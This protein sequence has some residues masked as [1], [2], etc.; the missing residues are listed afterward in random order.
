MRQL[1]DRLLNGSDN[2]T[3]INVVRWMWRLSLAA[4]LGVLLVFIILSFTNLPSV[5]E[6]E[7]PKT[8]EASLVLNSLGE[9]LGKY[10]APSQ[11]RVP[12]KFEELSPYL[13]NG[14]IATEDERYY[15]HCGID[16]KGLARAV[17]YLGSRGGASTIT[18]Q[19]AKQLF[20]KKVARN[21]PERI[22]Q[23]LK[24]WIIAV[25]LE[26]RYTKEE[27]IA[28]YLNRYDFINGAQG[29]RAAS[30][31]YFSKSAKDLEI[32]EAALLVGMLKNASLYDPKRFTERALKRREVVLKQMQKNGHLDQI[33]YDSLRQK[34]LGL[35][36]SRQTHIDGLAPYFRMVL[37]QE[38]KSILKRPE[39]PKKDN[40]KHFDIY[41]DGL[42]IYTTIDPV[43]QEVAEEQMLVNMKRLQKQFWRVWKK[44]DPWSYKQNTETEIPIEIRQRELEKLIRNSDRYQD[45]RNKYLS[46]AL[47]EITAAS[48]LTFS[49]DL[50]EVDYLF[51]AKQDA[52][53]ISRLVQRGLISSNLAARYRKAL[54]SRAMDNL[55]SQWDKLQAAKEEVFNKPVEM[56]IFTYDN[57]KLEKDSTMSPLDSIKYHRMFL[58]TGI[59]AVDPN[60]G[61]VRAWVGGI[62]HKW[63]QYDHVNRNTKRQVGSTFKPF[64]YAATIDLRGFSPC[65]PVLDIATTIEPGDGNF[66]LQK[67]WTPRNS[68]GTY[69]G[70]I[71]TLRDGLRNS[72]NTVSTYLMKELGSTDPVRTLVDNMGVDKDRVPDAPSIALGSV[73]LSVQE[74]TGA[75][76]TFANNGVFN[77]PTYL[78]RIE[79]RYGRVIYQSMPEERPALSP[80]ANYVMT[81]MLQYAASGRRGIHEVKGQA[82]GKTGTTNDYADGWFMGVTPNLVVGTWVGGE[83]RWISFLRI[84]E[85]QGANMGMPFFVEYIKA[86]QA[87][88]NV[89]WDFDKR[90]QRPRGDLGIILNC[91]EYKNPFN[92]GDGEG[93]EGSGDDFGNDPDFGR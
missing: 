91:D 31:I 93:D 72:K 2:P 5:R 41:R 67:P 78:L 52:A 13:V 16:F 7:N 44:K 30:E 66:Y 86:L 69:S 37:A 60:T 59:M 76:T 80:Q 63:F 47:N 74:M 4:V 29:I 83:D 32:E 9:P 1:I 14:L 40:N 92:D 21:Y 88:E 28:L 62:N 48:E 36:F 82:G 8:E 43:M 55:A 12:V 34:P 25:R 56:R 6:L 49:L 89:D 51:R 64:V 65:Y 35:K 39:T 70:S 73:D 71:Y 22:L 79:D 54:Q 45:L 57:A 24:E 68:S 53:Y 11:N 17:F 61:Y 33:S 23:K 84:R 81:E 19:L 38:V 87:N 10:Y 58:Q 27:I 26:R 85:G 20:T 75:Y 90:F 42:R 46:E 77:R 50:H 18:Q 15:K 3:H